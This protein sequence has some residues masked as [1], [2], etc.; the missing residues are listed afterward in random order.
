MA[1]TLT[2]DFTT[3]K[4]LTKGTKPIN[5][6]KVE[7]GGA[8]GTKWYS[9][10]TIGTGDASTWDNAEAR[11]N[12]WG[13]IYAKTSLHPK[14]SVGDV[15]IRLMDNDLALHDNL[16]SVDLE[17]KTVTIYQYFDGLV[18]ADLTTIFKG[19]I[20]GPMQWVEDGRE[21]QFDV[22][23]MGSHYDRDFANFVI[24]DDFPDV[25]NA[26]EGRMVPIVYGNKKKVPTV[27]AKG[28]KR[29]RLLNEIRGT[30]TSET[31]YIEGGE[32]FTQDPTEIT[33]RVGREH[34]TGTFTGRAFTPTAR[35]ATI[36]NGSIS[37]TAANPRVF[38]TNFTGVDGQYVGYFLKIQVEGHDGTL[39]WQTRRILRSTAG[40][41]IEVHMPF[42]YQGWVGE[43]DDVASDDL[44][45]CGMV[46]HVPS[47]T[48]AL[49]VTKATPHQ[50]G[51]QVFEV[52][53][54]YVYIVNDYPSERVDAVFGHGKR[55]A[56]NMMLD[57]MDG[58][59]AG[60]YGFMN[61]GAAPRL[62][63]ML[64]GQLVVAEGVD[65]GL[66]PPSQVSGAIGNETDGWA[67]IEPSMFAVDL[68]DSQFSA[69]LGHNCTTITFTGLP[70]ALNGLYDFGSDDLFVDIAG[71]DDSGDGSGTV[72]TN[73]A[74]IIKDFLETVGGVSAGETDDTSFTDAEGRMEG[75]VFGFSL[76]RPGKLMQIAQDLAFQCRTS[77]NWDDGVAFLRWLVNGPQSSVATITD[78]KRLMDSFVKSRIDFESE[79]RTG[80][81][82]TWMQENEEHELVVTDATA[83]AAF[84]RKELDM[85]CWA[86]TSRPQVQ[87]IANFW[88]NRLKEV[89]PIYEWKDYLDTIELQRND[90]L[91]L[92]VANYAGTNAEVTILEVVHTPGVG[93]DGQMDEI[94]YKANGW[95]GWDKDSCQAFCETG[96]CETSM[97]ESACSGVCETAAQ[98][99]C[100][101]TCVTAAELICATAAM[102][103][104]CEW[105]ETGDLWGCSTTGTE[106][107]LE[108]SCNTPCIISCQSSCTDAC[109]PGCQAGC[110]TQD[111]AKCACS[112]QGCGGGE[113]CVI[114]CQCQCQGNCEVECEAGQCQTGL[115]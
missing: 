18:E 115:E 32:D 23:D 55:R 65:P 26:H 96:G 37:G 62:Q 25:L 113:S 31:F 40:G 60:S 105:V 77:I 112:D 90:T 63:V 12:S 108:T 27:M 94:T 8:V 59:A 34:I 38:A 107:A 61:F 46:L 24:K 83:E 43:F 51:E 48:G 71:I 5:I 42:Y 50:E 114:T 64:P 73:P 2:G 101:L 99:M 70:P 67:V 3:K 72:I 45:G 6:V 106:T 35:G 78:N 7:W 57:D 97:Q 20:A 103:D 15:S 80:V 22:V 16:N 28:G 85:N 88:L 76:T 58:L 84:G 92:D 29:G 11:V 54:E 33:I 39:G 81:R 17:N 47:A 98:G 30:D 14:P 9:D 86:V 100:S 111:Q 89:L 49:I 41:E 44:F 109:E 95:W 1:R 21:L 91:L 19:T 93:K 87:T 10:Q 56:R 104:D 75:F 4:N 53:G 74:L 82:A 66:T 13:R 79:V 52:L 69:E 102:A 68:N 36:D 110:E